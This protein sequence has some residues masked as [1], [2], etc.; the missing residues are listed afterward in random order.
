VSVVFDMVHWCAHL[1]SKDSISSSVYAVE[2]HSC[3]D[4]V[5]VC[6]CVCVCVCV[7]VCER[8]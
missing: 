5:S 3:S 7:K 1:V 2:G 6:V 8:E 4:V